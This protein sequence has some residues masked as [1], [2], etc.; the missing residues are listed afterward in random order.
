VHLLGY[1]VKC[2]V[3]DPPL[4]T[5]T[6]C[7]KSPPSARIP[8]LTRVTRELVNLRSI[9]ALLILLA[10]LRFRWNSSSLVFTVCAY[11]IAFK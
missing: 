4:N 9:A 8:F 5:Q 10:A 2:T 3:T 6:W 11:T 7:S 1:V